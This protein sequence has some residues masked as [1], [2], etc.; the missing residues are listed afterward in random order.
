[1]SIGQNLFVDKLKE[2]VSQYNIAVPASVVIDAGATGLTQIASSPEVLRGLRL[3]YAASI[4]RT[5]IFALAAACIA[6]PF[7]CS[8]QWSNLT[9]VA[10]ERSRKEGSGNCDPDGKDKCEESRHTLGMV[11][12]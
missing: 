6:F 12:N 8:M 3:A 2:S 11:V 7:A 1:M 4:H 10:E 9:A 5:L